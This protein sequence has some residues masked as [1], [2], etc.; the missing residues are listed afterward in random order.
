MYRYNRS[1]SKYRNQKVEVDGIVFDSKR[2][3]NRYLELKLL[4]KAGEISN[5]EC[6]PKFD[7]VVNGM[8]VCTYYGDFRYKDERICKPV[9]EDVKGVRTHEY[10]IKKKL[11]KAIFDI[12]VVE[13]K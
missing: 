10:I 9:V 2:E 5:L 12:D 3:A 8:K 11:L 13:V 4:E 6:Q 1:K 7:L